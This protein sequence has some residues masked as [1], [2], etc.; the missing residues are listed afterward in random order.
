MTIPNQFAPPREGWEE[1]TWYLVDVEYFSTNPRHRSLFFSGFLNGEDNG[2]GGYSGLVGTDGYSEDY[3]SPNAWRST[4]Y[5][6]VVRRLF[7]EKELKSKEPVILEKDIRIGLSRMLDL[8]Q[9]TSL[10]SEKL[11]QECDNE[12]PGTC[13]NPEH[14][15]PTVKTVLPHPSNGME[16]SR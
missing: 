14:R 3:N 1:Q 6:R 9:S 15:F 8:L 4:Y 2:P 16:E 12:R 11:C 7:S 5:F 10:V 13:P